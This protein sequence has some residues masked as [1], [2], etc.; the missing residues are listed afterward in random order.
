MNGM[1]F[2]LMFITFMFCAVVYFFVIVYQS[3]SKRIDDMEIKFSAVQERYSSH[4]IQTNTELIS[5]ID[6]L[7]ENENRL[8]NF[9]IS[10]QKTLEKL[11]EHLEKLICKNG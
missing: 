8:V 2:G 7:H 11:I 10:H 9:L 4:I 3:M 1:I 5:H 6:R